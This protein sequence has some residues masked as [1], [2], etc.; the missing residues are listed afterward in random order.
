MND[1]RTD[2]LCRQVDGD[3]FY[4]DKGDPISTKAIKA[5]CLNCPVLVE[6]GEY[7]V[8][9]REPYGIWGGM[10][11][12]DR[13]LLRAERNRAAGVARPQTANLKGVA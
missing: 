6:C 8:E 11:V 7:A 4:P 13:A 12:R 2:G 1:W 5:V 9:A 10:S 3:L